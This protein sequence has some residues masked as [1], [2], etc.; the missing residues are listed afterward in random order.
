MGIRKWIFC[1]CYHLKWCSCMSVGQACRYDCSDMQTDCNRRHWVT[2]FTC[3]RKPSVVEQD[4]K[5]GMDSTLIWCRKSLVVEQDPESGTDSSLIWGRFA[6]SAPDEG[7]ISTSS[8]LC[9]GLRH[10]RVWFT[11]VLCKHMLINSAGWLFKWCRKIGA[12]TKMET[13]ADLE[14]GRVSI[15][16]SYI[17]VECQSFPYGIVL[18]K[19]LV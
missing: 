17:L 9:S 3:C 5:S 4:P 7:L 15:K 8:Y 6:G 12:L 13:H 11:A 19:W 18:L 10:T 16:K 1:I 14:R 2:M